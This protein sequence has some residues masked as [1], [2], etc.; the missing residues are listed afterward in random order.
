MLASAQ[1][2]PTRLRKEWEQMCKSGSLDSCYYCMGPQDGDWWHWKGS[3]S[4]PEGSLYE[5]GT[6]HIDITIPSSYPMKA[7][8]CIMTTKIYH[9]NI[10]QN[11]VI[12]LYMLTGHWSPVYKIS[13]ILESVYYLLL[14]PNFVD[15]LAPEPAYLNRT[16]I[17][18]YEETVREW[19]RKYAM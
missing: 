16:D 19:T 1:S 2:I 13:N 10:D 14:E 4:G 6:F 9:P 12:N 15:V 7:P 8:K 18:K 5:G 11:G 3:V 17:T